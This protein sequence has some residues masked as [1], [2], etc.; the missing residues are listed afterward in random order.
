MKNLYN[1]FVENFLFEQKFLNSRSAPGASPGSKVEGSKAHPN[2][3]ADEII[4]PTIKDAQ[5]RINKIRGSISFAKNLKLADKQRI[6]KKLKFFER[7][8]DQLES[9]YKN[10]KQLK[11][12]VV[13][14]TYKRL[15]QIMDRHGIKPEKKLVSRGVLEARSK[16]RVAKTKPKAKAKSVVKAK[17]IAKAQKPKEKRVKQEAI[18]YPKGTPEPVKITSKEGPVAKETTS[19]YF[20]SEKH[21]TLHKIAFLTTYLKSM[22][23]QKSKQ[24][25]ITRSG[26]RSSSEYQEITKTMKSV[27][28]E[29]TKIDKKVLPKEK[30][31]ALYKRA[32][33]KLKAVSKKYNVE[34]S[35]Y[36]P[37]TGQDTLNLIKAMKVRLKGL[38]DKAVQKNILS[39]L[40]SDEEQVKRIMSSNE[41][42]EVKQNM[43][44]ELYD[45]LKKG[46]KEYGLE[47][48]KVSFSG[49]PSPFA[50]LTVLAKP[51][52]SGKPKA[53]V[54]YL[55][56][57]PRKSINK[58][59]KY[60][61]LISN[62]RDLESGK[63]KDRDKVLERIGHDANTLRK[64]TS[65]PDQVFTHSLEDGYRV[66]AISWNKNYSHMVDMVIYRKGK[67]VCLRKKGVW[68]SHDEAP[69]LTRVA[70]VI[71][72]HSVVNDSIKRLTKVGSKNKET[73]RFNDTSELAAFKQGLTDWAKHGDMSKMSTTEFT[74]ALTRKNVHV[75]YKRR[76]P[77][78]GEFMIKLQTKK[79]G[80]R[81][82]FFDT[83]TGK[84]G[85]GTSEVQPGGKSKLK[86]KGYKKG[87][88]AMSKKEQTQMK[89]KSKE[90]QKLKKEKAKQQVMKN[91][92]SPEFKKA[93]IL[94]FPKDPTNGYEF[95]VEA[96]PKNPKHKELLRK[97]ISKMV[98][99][100]DM[101][102]RIA[103]FTISDPKGKNPRKAIFVP[104]QSIAS[105]IEKGKM[106]NKKVKISNKDKI[107]IDYR[108]HQSAEFKTMVKGNVKKKFERLKHNSKLAVNVRKIAYME[109]K[110]LE[111]K[112]KSASNYKTASSKL[113]SIK[114][115][116]ATAKDT[117]D[118]SRKTK[119]VNLVDKRIKSEMAFYTKKYKIQFPNKF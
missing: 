106:T 17:P 114:K 73:I 62:L 48:E 97:D 3:N 30:K 34:L 69:R 70:E 65:V 66:A 27:S 12:K 41:K 21:L 89:E 96:D 80:K 22:V 20:V 75:F 81:T 61:K 111:I 82:I 46:M 100:Q 6:E 72:S 92:I 50:K 60:R 45:L 52:T 37:P 32:N 98:N 1:R 103:I 16:T 2:M 44:K 83:D 79:L 25:K 13:L 71:K 10:R 99:L 39:R 9:K 105:L 91:N 94:K 95:S 38:K 119:I 26:V 42:P 116:L 84:L 5:E 63:F 108:D 67:V 85:L 43:M 102:H 24:L 64:N 15:R 4:K 113:K 54:Q 31:E 90:A 104:G 115:Q 18:H 49:K 88:A 47:K 51:V 29:L 23:E 35:P 14:A 76:G 68:Y 78:R 59:T 53:K 36:K 40:N 55:T 28:G 107:R 7:R 118:L 8:L 19:K 56:S 57:G 93:N 87:M 77:G 110:L 117:Y 11:E 86:S 33:D 112:G 109:K 74:P 101:T 58:I